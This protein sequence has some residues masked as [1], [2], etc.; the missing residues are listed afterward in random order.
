MHACRS[1]DW[2]GSSENNYYCYNE[3]EPVPE[4][5]EGYW[6]SESDRGMMKVAEAAIQELEKRGLK[7]HYLNITQLSEY[8]K[9]AHPSIFRKHKVSHNPEPSTITRSFVDCVHWCL[10]GLPDLWNQILYKY[11][12]YV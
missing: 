5:E 3:T 7:I 2:G 8:R 4:S 1:E 6:G 12:L 10:P 9:D 11:L